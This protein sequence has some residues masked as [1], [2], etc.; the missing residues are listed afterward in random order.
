MI[1]FCVLFRVSHG[2]FLPILGPLLSPYATSR[3]LVACQRIEVP[4]LPII[5]FAQLIDECTKI[6]WLRK[7]ERSKPAF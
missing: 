5:R 7:T 1:D 4:I 3:V 2:E 6:E